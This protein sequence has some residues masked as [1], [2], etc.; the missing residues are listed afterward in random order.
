MVTAVVTAM[1]LALLLWTHFHGGVPSHHILDQ[2]DL[3]AISNWWNALVLPVLTWILTGRIER[4]VEKQTANQEQYRAITKAIVAR[5]IA[6]L[7]FG[8][9]LALS[10]V[11]D[12]KIFLD[13]V[14]YIL[15]VLALLIPIFY[16]EFMLGFVFGMTYTFGAVLPT[17]FIL[18]MAAI[19]FLLYRFLRPLLLKLFRLR[20]GG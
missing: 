11:F 1:I 3:P 5:F 17:A 15:L 8:I 10:F 18:V 2:K 6:G 20:S 7:L 12:V 4:R 14:L 9:V 13:N 16:A 19:G